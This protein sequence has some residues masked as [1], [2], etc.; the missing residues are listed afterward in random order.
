MGRPRSEL[1]ALLE[2]FMPPGGKV[3]FQPPNGTKMVYPAIT[4]KRDY[5]LTQFANNKAYLSTKRYQVTVIDRNADSGIPEAVAALP[6]CTYSRFFAVD[7][8]NHDI[9]DL[10]F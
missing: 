9:F 6:L 3:Y 4:Y 7:N 5:R 8:L 10:Y 2:S 1:Q